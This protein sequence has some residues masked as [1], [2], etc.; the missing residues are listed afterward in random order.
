[1]Q[2]NSVGIIFVFNCFI[3]SSQ[4]IF[5]RNDRAKMT[6]LQDQT[7]FLEKEVCLKYSETKYVMN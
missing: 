3:F 6:C 2:M 5:P 4:C 1:M 7:E